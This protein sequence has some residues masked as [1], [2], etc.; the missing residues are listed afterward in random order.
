VS[1][2]NIKLCNFT[3]EQLDE[4]LKKAKNKKAAELDN[5]PPEILLQLS[6]VKILN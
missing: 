2:I 3:P 5:V 6:R 4:V 1:D